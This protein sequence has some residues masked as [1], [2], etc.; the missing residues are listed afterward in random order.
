M[1][2]IRSPCGGNSEARAKKGIKCVYGRILNWVAEIQQRG[3]GRP[4]QMLTEDKEVQY[5]EV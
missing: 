3:I 4:F 2:F 1:H 5:E